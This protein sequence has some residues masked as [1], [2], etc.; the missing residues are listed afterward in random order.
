MRPAEP[1]DQRFVADEEERRSVRQRAADRRPE[2]VALKVRL[3]ADVEV[4]AGV[5]RVVA[6]KLERAAG[7]A[8]RAGLRQDVDL[9]ARVAAELRAV[10]VRLD[11]ELTNRLRCRAPYPRRCPPGRS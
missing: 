3:A 11:A 6:V 1:L 9:P 5:E 4:V 2:L 7:E 8:V 10:G